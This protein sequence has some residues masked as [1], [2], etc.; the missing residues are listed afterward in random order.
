MSLEKIQLPTYRSE[1]G[2]ISDVILSYQIAGPAIG[3]APIV[4]VCHALTGN[5]SVAGPNGWWAQLIGEDQA[6]D[7]R[8]YS[9][10]CFDIPGNGYSGE[11]ESEPDRFGLKDVARLFLRG[12]E[13]LGIHHLHA[14]IGASMGGAL[15][16]QIAALA[17]TLADLIF[18]IATDYRASDWLL[19]QTEVQRLLLDSSPHPL[20]DARLHAMLCYR[21]PESL[22]ARFGGALVPDTDTP[23]VLDW[24]RY[25]GRALEERFLLSAYRT[26]TFLTADIHVADSPEGLAHIQS[27]IHLVS[28]DSDFLFPHFTAQRTARELS[29]LGKDVTLHTIYSIHGHDAFL[30]EYEQL[31]VIMSPY[32]SHP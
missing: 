25:H 15:V 10:L 20:R 17:P 13:S 5:S 11:P 1:K 16:W 4:M 14:I 27:E 18:P 19:A 23:R 7:T 21:T 9:I 2:V 29:A 32:F 24:L 22:S 3:T 31:N 6:I 30:M 8:H 28:I 26:M 12:L